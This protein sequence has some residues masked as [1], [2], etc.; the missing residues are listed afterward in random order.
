MI[1]A[2]IGYLVDAESPCSL[3]MVIRQQTTQPFATPFGTFRSYTSPNEGVNTINRCFGGGTP[4]RRHKYYQA[5]HNGKISPEEPAAMPYS[6][7][8]LHM[9]H[10]STMGKPASGILRRNHGECLCN[11]LVQYITRACG[12]FT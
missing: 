10:A 9:L 8:Q 2:L 12:F 11:G 5:Q 7:S 4:R 1:F 3:T 6:V